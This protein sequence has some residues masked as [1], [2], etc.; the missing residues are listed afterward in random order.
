MRWWH[1]T[2]APRSEAPNPTP[3]MRWRSN[4]AR[5]SSTPRAVVPATRIFWSLG[6]GVRRLNRKHYRTGGLARG[7]SRSPLR[8]R[9]LSLPG[10]PS[11]FYCQNA[12]GAVHGC[13]EKAGNKCEVIDEEPEL[14]L[15]SRPMR[16]PVERDGE[17]QH[18]GCG[19][20]CSFRKIYPGQETHDESELKQCRKPSQKVGQREARHRDVARCPVDIYQLET[21]R[22][23]ED[24]RED[25][26]S[27]EDR[28]R[29]PSR[30]GCFCCHGSFPPPF[31][32]CLIIRKNEAASQCV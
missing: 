18:I 2:R 13:K 17:E 27:C 7:A 6:P 19:Q 32:T 30:P 29:P 22:H 3:W 15:A 4:S 10:N 16:R 11:T 5:A 23:D 9:R 1:S 8:R 24:R 26:A 20:E 21:H 12:S 25:Q 14:G 31:S 28:R